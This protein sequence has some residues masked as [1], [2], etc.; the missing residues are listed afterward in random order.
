MSKK[1]LAS[2]LALLP[3]NAHVLSPE[4]AVARDE[5]TF[6]IFNSGGPIYSCA[7]DDELAVRLGL[8]QAAKLDLAPI[9]ELARV[10][11]LHRTT[12]HRD[13]AKLQSAGVEALQPK[14]RGPKGPHKLTVDA[15]R[16]AQSALDADASLRE[17]AKEV[18][19]SEF[20]I[21]HAIRKGLLGRG[22]ARASQEAPSPAPA[23][24]SEEADLTRPRER[25]E[26]DQ[27]SASGVA[28]KR[29]EER[30]LAAAGQLLE[31]PPHFESSE[32]VAGAGVLLALPALLREGL[33][34]VG[35]EV[36]GELRNGFFGL[37]SVLLTMEFMAL[38]RIQTPEQLTEHAPG[39]LGLLLGLDRAP[40]VKTLRR[41]LREIGERRLAQTFSTRLSERWAKAAPRELGLL[42]VDGHV[43]PYH[44]RTHLLPKHFVQQ[45]GRPMP[46]TRDF[47]VNDRR[48]DPLFFVTAEATEGLL[49]MLDAR[50]LPEIRR[51]VGRDRRVT[52]VLDREGWSPLRFAR[53]KE[54]GFDVLTYRKGAYAP[55]RASSFRCVRGVVGGESVEYRLAERSVR[56]K[57]GPRVREIRCLREKGPQTAVITTNEKL[58]MVAVAHRMFSRW[59]QENYF[60]YMREEFALDHLV[61]QEVEPA[62]PKRRVWNPERKALVR[63]LSA[64]RAARA[65][66]FERL[67]H[68]EP[69]QTLRV[70]KERVDAKE[71]KGRVRQFEAEAAGLSKRIAALPTR[72]SLDEVVTAKEIVRLER[73]RKV[74][75]D[76]VKLTAYRTE[77]SLARLL[78]P[79]F[80]RHE[81]EARKLLKTIF[82]ATGDLIPDERERRLIVRFHGLS[83]ARA[84]R[85]L[86]DLCEVVNEEETV[87]PGTEMRLRFEAPVSQK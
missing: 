73:E 68:L 64:V 30:A 41:K 10:G 1:Q 49:S 67:H 80:E 8:A 26:R 19:V 70:G 62:D 52:I 84:T 78:E 86:A 69:G 58:P 44:G 59:R 4:L 5:K 82:K 18:G 56:L 24:G 77:S 38:L 37:R 39:E 36:Y 17:A 61:T 7:Q 43:R 65:K 23:S 47:H 42:Y 81:E 12:L 57:G 33:L 25:A 51:L 6:T 46:G 35:D 40:E 72:V 87:F 31:A 32:A 20:A 53:W 45:R 85:A 48:V 3:P 22:G 55:W 75:V 79:F 83:S 13:Q 71:M 16:R 63:R 14:K 2:R 15:L 28:V 60:R 66:W 21:R 76:V 50:I 74:F 54:Q 34:E 11:G 29:I 27:A 9:T